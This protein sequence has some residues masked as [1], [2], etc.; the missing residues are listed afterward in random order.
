MWFQTKISLIL[1]TF[2]SLYKAFSFNE[3]T[4]KMEAGHQEKLARV[5]EEQEQGL[6]V[7][8]AEINQLRDDSGEYN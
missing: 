8:E 7:R 1:E 4:E 3:A 5:G 2:G 6:L